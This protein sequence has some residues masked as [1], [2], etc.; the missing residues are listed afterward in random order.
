MDELDTLIKAV[1]SFKKVSSSVKSQNSL[2]EGKLEGQ[3]VKLNK[4]KAEIEALEKQASIILSIANEQARVTL[5]EARLKYGEAK[6]TSDKILAE[7]KVE[8]SKA[9]LASHEAASILE[10]A[11]KKEEDVLKQ[12]QRFKDL[13]AALK[14][15]A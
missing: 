15:Y 11:K 13:Q 6:N 7:A 8:R 14:Q 10:S 12:E 4:L 9:A 3:T 5:D 1:D 2:L